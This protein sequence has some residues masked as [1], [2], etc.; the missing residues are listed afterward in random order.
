MRSQSPLIPS[1]RCACRYSATGRLQLPHQE[2]QSI[3]TSTAQT[4]LRRCIPSAS[5]APATSH[6]TPNLNP[7]RPPP[8]C[9]PASHPPSAQHSL[10]YTR[11]TPISTNSGRPP[12]L[13]GVAV[14]SGME[15]LPWNQ[16]LHILP[17]H[18]KPGLKRPPGRLPTAASRRL[19]PKSTDNWVFGQAGRLRSDPQLPKPPCTAASAMCCTNRSASTR[20]TGQAVIISCRHADPPPATELPGRS[21]LLVGR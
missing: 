10:S 2:P 1:C 19:A 5:Q 9:N 16:P 20:L 21:L 17:T 13:T 7:T 12:M 8:T 3:R 11:S 14:L 15:T 6:R 18:K 4:A